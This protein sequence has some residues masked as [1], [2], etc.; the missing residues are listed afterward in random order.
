M[1]NTTTVDIM[2]YKGYNI[3]LSTETGLFYA[4]DSKGNYEGRV[5][6]IVELSAIKS[7]LDA[8]V[9]DTKIELNISIFPSVDEV[10]RD[11]TPI[12]VTGV[13]TAGRIR[14]TAENNPDLFEDR[15]VH[16]NDW[17]VYTPLVAEWEAKTKELNAKYAEWI[18]YEKLVLGEWRAKLKDAPTLRDYIKSLD[19]QQ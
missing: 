11:Q 15:L 2:K 8:I 13:T 6:G 19:T 16:F 1:T 5:H 9:L 12:S 17:L 10:E 7:A 14:Y 3:R 4:K 18:A